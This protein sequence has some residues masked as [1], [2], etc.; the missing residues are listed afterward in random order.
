METEYTALPKANPLPT[1]VISLVCCSSSQIGRSRVDE[2][3][4]T[5]KGEN[6]NSISGAKGKRCHQ[7]PSDFH[8]QERH[9]KGE[10][11]EGIISIN[12]LWS[13]MPLSYK[14]GLIIPILQ[15]R[16]WRSGELGNLPVVTL[17]IMTM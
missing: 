8:E 3:S 14:L 13:F 11:K 10:A 7:F 2:S 9:Y 15:M 4:L 16:K 6:L 12:K 17:L 5:Y 1:K